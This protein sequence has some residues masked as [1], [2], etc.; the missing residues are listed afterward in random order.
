[1]SSMGNILLEKEILLESGTNEL[2]VLVFRV[3]D[4]TFGINVAKVREVLSAQEITFLPKA[5]SSIIGVFKLRDI[6]IPCVSLHKHLQG[7]E[8]Q[9]ETATSL[10]L[11]DF[12]NHQTAFVVDE[13]ERI[14]RLSWEH[15]LAVPSLMALANTPVTAVATI[16]ERL[17]IM[18]DFEMI[19]DQVTEQFFRTAAVENPYN[20]ERDKLRILLAE[21]SP[22]VREAVGNTLRSSGYTNLLI[23]DNGEDA[24][25]WIDERIRATGDVSQVADLLI[26]DVEMPRVDGFHLTKRIKD[27]PDLKRL[28]VLLYSSIVSPDNHKK[29]LSVG[30]DAQISKPD[31][32]KVVQW[33]D[34]LITGKFQRGE[35]VT[36]EPAQVDT[37][38]AAT[39]SQGAAGKATAENDVAETVPAVATAAGSSSQQSPDPATTPVAPEPV[40]QQDTVEPPSLAIDLSLPKE[41]AEPSVPQ[42]PPGVERHLWQTFC[43]ELAERVSH[44]KDLCRTVDRGVRSERAT[45]E[46]FRTLH[47]IKSASMVVPVDEVT[48]LTHQIEGLMEQARHD[49]RQWPVGPMNLFVAWLSE[50]IDP[51]NDVNMVLARADELEADFQVQAT[52]E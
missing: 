28:P 17:I 38:A 42:P 21:D 47:T 48:R 25:R 33:A 15:V 5:H 41:T 34:D 14:H 50:L 35:T 18:L 31:L 6:V 4:C 52:A 24:W 29:G 23:F 16:E 20:L 43:R 36:G 22:T 19:S 11:T 46:T 39:G 45:N 49:V 13:V 3:A 7:S 40:A 37:A 10:I 8:T 32:T 1:M 51:T 2:E 44:L 27:H 9:D 26:S 12:N 30:A